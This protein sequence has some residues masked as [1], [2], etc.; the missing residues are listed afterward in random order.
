MWKIDYHLQSVDTVSRRAARGLMSVY[1]LIR[2]IPQA[3]SPDSLGRRVTIFALSCRVTGFAA[4]TLYVSLPSYSSE[5]A[6]CGCFL[7]HT[8]YYIITLNHAVTRRWLSKRA[9]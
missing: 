3:R 9:K 4:R 5:H 8:V 2:N 1:S 6:M 7:H